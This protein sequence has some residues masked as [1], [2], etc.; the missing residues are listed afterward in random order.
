MDIV[1]ENSP[2]DINKSEVL[3]KIEA[4][5]NKQMVGEIA[6]AIKKAQT[7]FES[8]IFGFGV[9]MHKQHPQEWKAIKGNW[10]DYFANAVINI[11]V[12]STIDRQGEFKQPF[13]WETGK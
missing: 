3:K 8:D 6:A 12:E 7:E 5:F 4:D 1:Q 2:L 9:S 10:D 11:S 13:R